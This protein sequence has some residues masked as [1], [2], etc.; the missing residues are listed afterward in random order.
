M[1]NYSSAPYLLNSQTLS[2]LADP[3]PPDSMIE[4]SEDEIKRELETA[5]TKMAL[6]KQLLWFQEFGRYGLINTML[7]PLLLKQLA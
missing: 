6:Q 4:N 7:Q 2:P 1:T 3:L 5:Q